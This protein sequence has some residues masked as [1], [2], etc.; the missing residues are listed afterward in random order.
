MIIGGVVGAVV[1][2]GAIVLAITFL[3][4]GASPTLHTSV[5]KDVQI[6]TEVPDIKGALEAFAS[7]DI[8]TEG[9]F[10]HEK[11]TKNIT[12]GLTEAFEI[13]KDEATNI[14][15]S[16]EA[17]ATATRNPMK[18]SREASLIKFSDTE[19]MEALLKSERFSKEDKL[20]ENG[21][22]YSLETQ[23]IKDDEREDMSSFHKMFAF[24]SFEKDSEFSI[25]VWFADHS[26]L[27]TGHPDLVEDI[28]K[29][30]EKGGD[31]LADN[32]SFKEASWDSGSN[33]LAWYD[34]AALKDIKGDEEEQVVKGLFNDVGPFSI[35]A[36]LTDVG[37]K[38]SMSGQL[39]GKFLP[40]EGFSDSVGLD[41]YEKLPKET[42]AY[43]AVSTKTDLDGKAMRKEVFKALRNFDKDQAEQFDKMLDAMAEEFDVELEK[44]FDAIGDQVVMALVL[45]EKFEIDSD[46]PQESLLEATGVWA[47]H[48]GDKDAADKIVKTIRQKAFEDGPMKESYDVSKKDGGFKAEPK[49]DGEPHFQIRFVEDYLVLAGGGSDMIKATMS[50][51]DSG[52]GTLG[53][54]DAHNK[55]IGAIDKGGHVVMWADVGRVGQ[56]MLD[57]AEENLKEPVEAIEEELEAAGLSLKTVQL[58]GENRITAAGS[59]SIDPDGETW[60]FR[61]D[62]LN[63]A[64]PALIGG[65]AFAL[66]LSSGFDGPKSGGG[67]SV[68]VD[69]VQANLHSGEQVTINGG[70]ACSTLDTDSANWIFLNSTGDKGCLNDR[71]SIIC[72]LSDGTDLVLATTGEF[73]TVAGRVQGPHPISG[74]IVVEDCAVR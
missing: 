71:P 45:P 15:E 38:A 18:K 11:L 26:L 66:V 42:V 12:D 24:Q 60:N 58:K 31:S 14:V 61:V 43:M 64:A 54:D 57:Y 9:S 74:N 59:L 50:A 34:A 62:T 35:S 33:V 1:L 53:D 16:V 40:E 51:F 3:G 47:I 23:K 25:L 2:I 39:N 70:R 5:P 28:A 56:T 7:M 37:M 17:M 46:K 6:Y 13:K 30:V 48:V 41:I 32:E 69:A 10:K 72:Q 68:S 21:Q 55:A 20:G 27:V 36:G 63:I 73:I 4:G 8:I 65:A 29:V 44:V 67:N 52:K 22:I 49:E 19:G